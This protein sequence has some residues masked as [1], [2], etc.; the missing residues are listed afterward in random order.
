M[1]RIITIVF[2]IRV[3]LRIALE[4]LSQNLN[5]CAGGRTAAGPVNVARGNKLKPTQTC[6]K[7]RA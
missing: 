6:C 1:A 7:L 3:L 5:E 4:F 2:A